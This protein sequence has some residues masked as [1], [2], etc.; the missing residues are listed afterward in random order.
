MIWL[1]SETFSETPIKHG[2]Y[3]YAATCEALILTYAFAEDDPVRLWDITRGQPMPG[4]LEY[5]LFDTDEE[6]TAHNAMFDRTVLGLATNLRRYQA[7]RL[8]IERWRCTMAQAL[9][10]S[11]PGSLDKLCEILNVPYD[12]R[13]LKTGRALMRLFT[14]PRPKNS[15][16]RRATRF[17][18]PVEWSQF[19]EYATHDISAMRVVARK[20]PAW[21]Y[22]ERELALWHLDQRINDRGMYVDLDFAR[23]AIRAVE[24]TQKRLAAKTQEQTDGAVASTTQRDQLLA[25]ILQEYG[26]ELPD[27]Q[28]STIERRMRD[29]DLPVELKDLLATRL[30]SATTSTSKY[31]ALVRGA[32]PDGRLRGTLQFAGAGRTARW[33]GRVFQP[34]NLP[35]PTHDQEAINEFIDACKGDFE[36]L[37][38]GDVMKLAA[39]AIRGC[40]IAP[41]NKKLVVADLSNI[42][43]RKAA[44]LAGEDW[45]LQAF[46]DFDAG[47]GE[48]LYKVSYGR[49]FRIDPREVTKLQRQV[50]KVMELMLQYEGGVGAFVTGAATYG[51]N[52]DE[53]AEVAWP[54]LPPDLVEEARGFLAWTRKNKRPTFGLSDKVFITCD[55]LKRLWRIRHPAITSYWPELKDA[56]I[57]AIAH[58]GNTVPCRRVKI[59]CEG[60]WLRIGLPSGRALCYPSPRFHEDGSISYLGV[61]QYTRAWCRIKT[62]GGKLFE[63]ITQAS[64][65]DVLAYHMPEIEEQH[66]YEFVLTVHDE[67]VTETPDTPQF[68]AEHLAELMT[69]ELEWHAGLPLAAAGFE[70][71]RYRKE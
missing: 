6:I 25:Y 28:A 30:E 15:K 54:T 7:K 32:D 56:V 71:Y 58:P 13:K 11:L 43:G 18:H 53:L 23:A 35:R 39:S 48:D 5:A 66:G 12:Q 62:Y 34:H 16:L 70:T 44:W 47:K 22:R 55:V 37:L 59:R 46:R 57:A 14:Q 42:E 41:D 9:A 33:A 2:T 65:R 60:A 8:V 38:E 68:N 24:R 52:L 36:D 40:I 50:G 10:H 29:N 26:V 1:D 20:L 61:N 64:S 31:S 3:R 17:T 4:D 67:D 49:A 63:N 21:N 69:T 19:C 45:K 27:M 51:V